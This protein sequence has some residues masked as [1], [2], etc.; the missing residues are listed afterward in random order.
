MQVRKALSG[1]RYEPSVISFTRFPGFR[2]AFR[3]HRGRLE[4]LPEDR[5]FFDLRICAYPEEQNLWVV[6]SGDG[7]ILV[8]V[9]S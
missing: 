5:G 1:K 9:F 3:R 4:L 2:I 7:A 8:S 6:R